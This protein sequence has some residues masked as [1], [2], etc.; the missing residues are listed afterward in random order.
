MW[1]EGILNFCWYSKELNVHPRGLC[2]FTLGL[3]RKSAV[4]G[5]ST[6]DRWNSLDRSPLL[7]E[8]R[9]PRF[10]DGPEEKKSKK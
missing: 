6:C 7:D 5:N 10:G 2:T 1:Y 8:L 4:S 9:G 3:V